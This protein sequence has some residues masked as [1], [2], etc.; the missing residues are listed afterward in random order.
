MSYYGEATDSIYHFDLHSTLLIYMS[1]SAN[2]HDIWT[3][4]EMQPQP[5]SG[6]A[7]PAAAVYWSVIRSAITYRLISWSCG[8]YSRNSE[9]KNVICFMWLQ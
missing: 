3:V 9:L 2:L 7:C 6:I 5:Q 1:S 4:D 8:N